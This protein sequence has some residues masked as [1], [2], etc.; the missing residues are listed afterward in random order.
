[1]LGFRQFSSHLTKCH[2][3]HGICTQPWQCDSQKN[4]QRNTSKV[5]RLPRKMTMEVAQVLRLPRKMQLIFSKQHKS[6][7]SATQNDFG[8]VMKHVGMSQCAS[9]A[10]RNEATRHLQPPKVQRWP[11]L[12]NSHHLV[13]TRPLPTVAD[14]CVTSG[15]HSLNPLNPQNETGTLATH[16]GKTKT[17]FPVYVWQCSRLCQTYF[18]PVFGAFWSHVVAVRVRWV[19]GIARFGLV[20]GRFKIFEV[21]LQSA[22]CFWKDAEG[23]VNFRCWATQGLMLI[24]NQCLKLVLGQFGSVRTLLC[25]THKQANTN[26][27]CRE[28]DVKTKRRQEWVRCHDWKLSRKETSR[29]T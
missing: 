10:T 11:L 18:E 9:P 26:I 6:I 21:A 7:A 25:E 4:T 27:I 28:R 17:I 15:E 20:V 5:L 23:L 19:P 29:G 14:G 3:Y 1:M 16:S 22:C 2:A 12:Q 13:L 8:H 24:P